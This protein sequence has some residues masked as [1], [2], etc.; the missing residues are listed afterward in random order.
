[1]WNDDDMPKNA[2]AKPKNLDPMSVDE[3]RDYILAL[4]A[5][6]ERAEGEIAKKEASKAAAAAFFR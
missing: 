3:L 4:R 1:M 5:E 2:A 6:I